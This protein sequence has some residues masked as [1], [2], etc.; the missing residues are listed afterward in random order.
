M[1]IRLEE[2]CRRM[3]KRNSLLWPIVGLAVILCIVFYPYIFGGKI[4]LPTDM[5]D[6]M[7]S[8]SNTQY[9]PPQAQNH[10]FYDGIVQTYPYKIAT[11]EA[12]RNGHLAYWNPHILCG[13]PQYAETMG[14]NFDPFNVLLLWT[15][16]NTSILVETVL[17]LFI[18]GLGML[19]LLRFFGVSPF[20]NLIFSSAYML[21]SLFIASAIHRWTVAS[22]C[23]VPFVI[24]MLVR[25]LHS[26]KK[27]HLL[28]AAF[29]LALVFLGGNFQSSFFASCLVGGVV[30]LFPSGSLNWYKRISGLIVVG[31]AAFLLSAPMW[32]PTL[33]LFWRTLSNGSLNSSSI[34]SKYSILQRILSLPMLVMFYIPSFLGSPEVFSLKKVAGVDVDDFNGAIAFVPALFAC[35]GCILFWKRK[36]IRPFIVMAALAILLPILTPLYSILYHRVFIIATF[37]FCVIGAVMLQSFVDRTMD[38][39]RIAK[40]VGR[41]TAAFGIFVL[42]V[43]A[44]CGSMT[45]HRTALTKSLTASLKATMLK[46]AFG[47]GNE[48]WMFARVGKT[49]DYFSFTSIELWLPILFAV[50]ALWALARYSNAKLDRRT[51]LT[52]T[53]TLTIAQLILFAKLWFPSVDP[54]TFPIYPTNPIITFLQSQPQGDRFVTWRDSTKDAFI[55]PENGANIYH[56][57][58]FNGY[59]SLTAPSMSVLYRRHIR[60]DSLD[61]RLLGLAGVKWVV[62]RSYLPSSP[63]AHPV[64]SG[65]GL[66]VYE[67]HLAKPRAYFAKG[68]EILHSDTAITTMLLSKDFDGSVALFPYND[69]PKDLNESYVTTGEIHTRDISNEEVTLQTKTASKALLILT[70]TYYPGWKCYVNGAER[71]V[72]RVNNYMRGVFLDAGTSTVDFR[73][74]PMLFTAGVATSGVTALILLGMLFFLKF[75]T[76]AE[77]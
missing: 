39:H 17:E 12:L 2:G 69:A 10:Y 6:T 49:F 72:Y 37:C 55:L 70:D 24:L 59:E 42:G 76:H 7:T 74:E 50:T 11:Q 27:E 30:F 64:F 1:E 77:H 22:F 66:T 13:Y 73:F 5:Y 71:P 60:P 54:V 51:L 63:N 31:G 23:W 16:V 47:A 53:G 68:A 3:F 18:A 4:L 65:N 43:I 52:I 61:L 67:N 8:P 48:A 35:W 15:S 29:F 45:L 38:R 57:N 41:S 32:L 9:S 62:A 33:E 46:T 58:D 36:E 75:R 40:L 20:V 28:F 34:Y 14:N 56:I 26:T 25:Y 21:N 19:F 44:L